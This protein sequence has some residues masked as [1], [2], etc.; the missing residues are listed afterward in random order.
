MVHGTNLIMESTYKV[1][2]TEKYENFEVK[3]EDKLK[4]GNI[5][6]GRFKNSSLGISGTF[7]L[8]REILTRSL[9]YL[10]QYK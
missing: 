10:A 7:S 5:L 6:S 9:K 1:K 2:W 4:R 3:V 8:D